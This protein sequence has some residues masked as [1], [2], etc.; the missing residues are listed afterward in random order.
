MRWKGLQR[1]GAAT[2]LAWASGNAAEAL[3]NAVPYMQVFGHMVIAWI[4]FDVLL[5]EPAQGGA[6]G[7]EGLRRAA[8]YL[9]HY[10]TP[11]LPAWLRVVETLDANCA[12]MPEEAL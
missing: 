10:E 11:R 1:L 6:S 8:R 3:A 9:F 7:E 2:R 12:Q 5:A 4:W